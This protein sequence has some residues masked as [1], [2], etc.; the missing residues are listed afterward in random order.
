MKKDGFALFAVLILLLLMS[1]VGISI[2]TQSRREEKIGTDRQTH[3]ATRRFALSA[4]KIALARLQEIAGTDSVATSANTHAD[5]DFPHLAWN[6]TNP[7]AGFPEKISPDV[8]VPLCSA[9]IG[10]REQDYATF[11]HKNQDGTQVSAPWEYANDNFRF[12][13]FIIDESQ[14]FPLNPPR[15]ITA[16]ERSES[17]K[18][19]QEQQ[20]L[21]N[22]NYTING[23]ENIRGNTQKNSTKELQIA[24]YDPAYFF[25]KNKSEAICE[26]SMTFRSFGVI[27][28]WQRN[29][30]KKNLSDENYSDEL[31]PQ[32]LFK[33]MKS[34]L[35]E[36]PYS[37]IPIARSEARKVGKLGIDLN[38]VPVPA[39]INLHIGFINAR[40]DGQHRVRFHVS[41]KLWNP[42]AFPILAHADGQ[43]GLIDFTT[44]PI[45]FIQNLNTGG[46]F[47]VDFSDFPT[48]RFGL[49]RQTPSDKTLNAYCRI[50]DDSDQGFGEDSEYPESGL[51]A[52]EIYWARFPDPKGQPAGLSR[53]SGGPTWKFQKKSD[54][55][56]AP[57]NTI[58]GR[59]FHDLHRINIFSMPSI[60][61]GEIVL[62]HYNGNFPQ[63]T[64]PKDY[65]PAIIRLKNIQ[66]PYVDFTITGK[67]YNREKA[68]DYEIGEANLVYK[69]QLKSES[70]NAM[71]QLL[72]HCDLRSGMFDFN[73]PVIASA[74]EIS[75]HTGEEARQLA[76][77]KNDDGY[78][79]DRFLNEHKTQ[80]AKIPFSSI[81][82]YDLPDKNHASA[83]TLR[84]IQ[85]R[86]LPPNAIGKFS[87]KITSTKINQIIDR[88]FFSLEIRNENIITS[89]NPLF[90]HKNK[91][92]S[93]Y[94][95]EISGK[96]EFA[97]QCMIRGSFN[98]NSTN[99][100][101]WSALLKNA[102]NNWIQYSGRHNEKSMPWDKTVPAKNFKNVFFTRPFSAQFFSPDGKIQAIGDA[103]LEKM[104]LRSREQFLLGQGL[105][106]VS[107]DSIE[108]LAQYLAKTIKKKIEMQEPFLSISNF[109][110]SGLLEKG[111]EQANINII[112]GEKIP[113]WF[114][115]FIRQEHI[116]EPLI[117]RASPRGDSFSI[118]LR[119]E[120]INPLTR[121]PEA[122]AN[123]EMQVQRMPDLFD[124]T[125]RAGTNYDSCNGKN[126][127][128][129]RRFKI[130][131]FK[132]L[133]N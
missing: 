59:W 109:A 130:I 111:I 121:K 83:G 71:K 132:F 113:A 97:E 63:S 119:A 84:F 51:H 7:P 33:N 85:M 10:H 106:S 25:D 112:G 11:P 62:R 80:D 77:P 15:T 98:I 103:D 44:M 13:Y 32:H 18:E 46:K 133:P 76:D 23:D 42:N 86:N 27:A 34:A 94:P 74:F 73:D 41:A 37:G 54:P 52:G 125:Q 105:R 3:L 9:R 78:F 48:G 43:L 108:R 19:K 39:E 35:P 65:A 55:T 131:S 50:F 90:V 4:A 127:R 31:F 49:V 122:V 2:L 57:Y 30:L 110:D 6:V 115:N 21:L 100:K 82:I 38:V 17:P 58:D 79:F 67:E 69:I 40:S 28:D 89:K 1:S 68:G 104:P 75:V 72:E 8:P 93:L 118:I 88:Y 66:L 101:A 47:S 123:L 128:F 56:K 116:L 117:L 61:P 5:R 53:I 87:Q 99:E 107:P 20:Q 36:F 120:K 60:L 91:I 129:G 16:K 114:P 81:Q 70:E 96:D 22:F 24:Q 126:R 124:S 45:F 95:I 12:S 26:S 14:K 102:F 29:R 92:H 64:H